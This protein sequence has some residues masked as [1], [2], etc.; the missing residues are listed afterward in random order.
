[1]LNIF[2]LLFRG[3]HKVGNMLKGYLIMMGIIIICTTMN[4]ILIG[5]KYVAL[6]MVF[7]ASL[8]VILYVL[9]VRYQ[10]KNFIG[11]LSSTIMYYI[12]NTKVTRV[13]DMF[14]NNNQHHAACE[15]II[16]LFKNIR[17][18]DAKFTFKKEL[19]RLRLNLEKYK[20]D[21][22]EEDE[23]LNPFKNWFYN[24]EKYFLNSYLENKPRRLL[25][26]K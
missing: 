9:S 4:Y 3:Q 17:P 21:F 13:K 20:L 15:E 7:I 16:F 26:K 24:A 10:H 22:D 19:K 23:V 25:N 2:I 14:I 1:M 18:N 11:I 5:L 6:A 8:I 12:L